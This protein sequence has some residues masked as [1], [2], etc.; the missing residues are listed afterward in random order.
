ARFHE[1]HAY[2]SSVFAKAWF[3]LTHR[4]LGPKSRYIGPKAPTGD[5]LWQD[6]VP[7]GPTDYDVR[8]LKQ[9]IIEAPLS[10]GDSVATAWDSARTF[11]TSDKR[12][13]ANGAR[14]RLEPAR[15]WKG[16][17]PARLRRSLSILEEIARTSSAS[18]A[19]VIVLAGNVA[20]EKA[21]RAAGFEVEVPFE[22]GRGDSTQKDTDTVGFSV[23]E[24]KS[25]GYRNWDPAGRTCSAEE[26]LI[27][28]THLLD[29]TVPEMVVLV[30]GM[31]VLGT[32]YAGTTH[33]QFTHRPGALTNDF[34]VNTTDMRW[35]WAE[36]ADGVFELCDRATGE[37]HWT[38]TRVDLLFGSNSVLRAY[39]EFYAQDDSK[40]R[41]VDHF[42]A[43]W[44]K[45]MNADR[46]DLANGE[47]NNPAA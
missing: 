16:N 11:R 13:G 44:T 25:D 7:A 5:L 37:T 30:G 28:Q 17:E 18:I 31:R 8:S 12:G 45:L 47:S 2:F 34:F 20:I 19:D 35:R 43:A 40:E 6:P 46:F 32:N 1:D 23:L 29:L 3:K 21:A 10:I 26:R 15:N 39:S 33:G 22:P 4:D 41:F 14:I 9:R 38:A 36:S 27:E 24:P 42:V